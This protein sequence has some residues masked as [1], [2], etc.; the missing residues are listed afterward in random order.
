MSSAKESGSTSLHDEISRIMRDPTLTQSEK[1][2]RIQQAMTKNWDAHQAA[3][4]EAES[5]KLES[6]KMTPA[7]ITRSVLEHPSYHDPEQKVLGCKHYARD[8]LIRAKCCGLVFPCRLCHDEHVHNHKIDRYST[9]EIVCGRC[10]TL[11]PVSNVCISEQ[12]KGKP[13]G[14]WYCPICKFWENSDRDIYHCPKCNVC[15]VGKGLGIDR[16][17]CDTCGCCYDIITFRSHKCIPNKLGTPCPVCQCDMLYSREPSLFMNC[18]HCMHVSC[19]RR[20]VESGNVKCPLCGRSMVDQRF[21]ASI[22][23][24]I[25]AENPMPEE[26]ANTEA[27]IFCNDCQATSRVPFSFIAHQCP[28]CLSYNTA[29]Q[30]IFNMPDKETLESLYARERERHDH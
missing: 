20:L 23:D 8:C 2:A 1:S 17:H 27:E 10:G 18:G 26:F 25:K 4:E 29:R 22:Y 19:C 28:R 12:C 24:R 5:T 14:K 9:E 11:Q 15:R 21:I 13:F 6:E 3:E 16:M 7:E 30:R